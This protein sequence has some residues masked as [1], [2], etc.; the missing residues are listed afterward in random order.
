MLHTEACP[1]AAEYLP[2][3]RQIVAT[4]GVSEPVRVRVIADADEAQ[5]ERF[6][7]SPTVRVNGRDV[8]PNA[9][10][11]S[12]FGLSCRLYA[13]TNGM[14]GVPIDEWV[15]NSLRGLS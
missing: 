10:R 2:R 13:G 1:H 15:L 12:D 7:G 3:L 8:E 6:L 4:A 14:R 11:R 5:R 9:D